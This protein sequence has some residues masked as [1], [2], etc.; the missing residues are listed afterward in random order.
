MILSTPPMPISEKDTAAR[1]RHEPAA[2][3]KRTTLHDVHLELGAHFTEFAGWDMP[4]RYTSDVAEHHAV[5]TSAGIFDL[6]HMGEVEVTGAEAGEALD[7][8][9]V[10]K[11]SGMRVGQARYN[12]ICFE[13][14]GILDDLVVYRLARDRYMV[15]ANASNVLGVVSALRDRAG[16]YDAAVRDATDEWALIAVQGPTS[17]QILGSTTEADLANLKYY[18]ILEARLLGVDVLLARTGYTGE[19]GFEIYCRSSVAEQV[20]RG[21]TKAGSAHGLVPA[22]LACRDT[23][24]LEA[25]MPLYGHELGAGI[26]PFEAGLGRVVNFTKEGGFVGEA[27]LAARR[28]AGVSRTLVGLV[29]DGRRS[30]RAGYPVIDPATGEEVGHVTSGAPSPTLGH[31]IAIASLPIQF[32]EVGTRLLVDVRGAKEAVRVVALPFYKR[33]TN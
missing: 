9:V 31:P 24:R 3:P 21:V 26:T 11:P 7:Y 27:A 23:L 16:S 12:M 18:A 6:S 33:T 28:D 15:V 32:Q 30:T 1:D 4:V 20:W 29:S 2:T 5:R 10:G 8:A 13:D 22:G 19:D 17:S 14:G 25:G